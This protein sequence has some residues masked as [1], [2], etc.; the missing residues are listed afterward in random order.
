MSISLYPSTIAS[1]TPLFRGFSRQEHSGGL[2]FPPARDLPDPGIKSVSPALMSG[3]GL[4]T[5]WLFSLRRPSS[6]VYG[7]CGRVNS[8]LQ[9]GFCQGSPSWTPVAC[10]PFLW[11]APTD[12][13]LHGGPSSTSRRLWFSLLWGRCSFPL[14]LIA[15]QD[16]NLCFPQ[17][18]GSPVIKSHWPSRPDSMRIPGPSVVSPGWETRLG[19]QNL[20]DSFFGL[21]VLQHVG[22]PRDGCG[23]RFYCDCAPPGV[24]LLLRLWTWNISFS[25]GF[26]VLLSVVV[27][28]LVVILELSRAEM[29]AHISTLSS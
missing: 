12:P 18:C 4:P 7:L 13:L 9:E 15:L 29:S 6:G 10:A 21:T 8:N 28:Q 14:G 25:G 19:A 1:R 22:H 3:G 27:Q 23:I 2:P 24:S 16:G 11:R 17:S 26:R 5:W 20:Q